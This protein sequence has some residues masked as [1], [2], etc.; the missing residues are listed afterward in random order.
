MNKL[1]E[2]CRIGRKT[3]QYKTRNLPAGLRVKETDLG[4]WIIVLKLFAK[5]DLT[6]QDINSFTIRREG[7]IASLQCGQYILTINI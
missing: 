3:P 6:V 4:E 5:P 2:V 1:K 7:F